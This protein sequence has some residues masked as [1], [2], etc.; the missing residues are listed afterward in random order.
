M[1]NTRLPW[2][3]LESLSAH[4]SASRRAPES[5]VTVDDDEDAAALQQSRRRCRKAR[6]PRTTLAAK[7]SLP[8]SVSRSLTPQVPWVSRRCTDRSRSRRRSSSMEIVPATVSMSSPRYRRRVDGPACL[9][10]LQRR[11]SHV[12]TD[13]AV[14]MSL[15]HCAGVAAAMIRSSTYMEQLMPREVRNCTSSPE[16]P[17]A[18]AGATRRP[19]GTPEHL[20]YGG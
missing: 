1:R 7:P 3:A 13:T 17:Q 9:S 2:M 19:R 20:R 5:M 14:A 15:A 6:P 8:I 16:M 18:N 4:H 10:G 11:P 12:K